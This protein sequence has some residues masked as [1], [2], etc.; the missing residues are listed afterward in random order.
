MGRIDCISSAHCVWKW[1]PGTAVLRK[2]W[3]FS[4]GSSRKG[5]MIDLQRLPWAQKEDMIISL[6]EF[7]IF[8]S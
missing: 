8:S 7:L 4:Y 6:S 5:Y 2:I 1:L 3:N